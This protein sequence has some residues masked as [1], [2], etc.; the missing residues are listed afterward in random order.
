MKIETTELSKTK[1]NGSSDFILPDV[2]V[3]K[4]TGIRFVLRAVSFTFL[5]LFIAAIIASVVIF[6]VEMEITLEAN[7]ILEP[8]KVKQIHSPQSALVN[9]VHV[10]SGD[11]VSTGQILAILDSKDLKRNLFEIESEI[12]TLQNNLNSLVANNRFQ[13]RE[14]QILLKKSEAMLIRSKAA[15][16]E[17]LLDYYPGA[18][19]DSIYENYV[20]GSHI[21][22]DYA[23]AEIK[24]GE[25]EV[26]NRKL[27]KEKIELNKYEIERLKI[28]LEK[29]LRQ[30]EDVEEKL[31]KVKITAPLN[32]VVLT[33]YIHELEE[34]F[35][36]EGSLLLEISDTKEWNAILFVNEIDVH[37]VKPG[38]K[39][40]I[41]LQAL[42][43]VENIE[44]IEASVISIAAEQNLQNENY[45]GFSG[46][47]RVTAKLN[48]SNQE[49]IIVDKLKHGY[50][51]SGF[52]I[53]DHGVIYKLLLKY[54]KKL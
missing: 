21:T 11:T 29:S 3:K 32:G 6:T 43:A 1:S 53:T 8:T 41:E 38:N 36:N 46:L 13:E 7:G 22:L 31:L 48:I 27:Q 9:E 49:K 4:T 23:M 39:V 14:N 44:M 34:T 10:E 42:Q 30:K 20:P 37:E 15:F 25:Y 35:V 28:S 50:N 2:D 52:I 54:F 47:Y 12:K 18:D 16:R 5:I 17:R 45:S 19:P 24:S 33:E 51:V 40:K 26:E